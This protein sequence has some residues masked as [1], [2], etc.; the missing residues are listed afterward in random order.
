MED[1]ICTIEVSDKFDLSQTSHIFAL[2][3]AEKNFIS[4]TYKIGDEKVTVF[5]DTRGRFSMVFGDKV[6]PAVTDEDVEQQ[7]TDN[8]DH[9]QSAVMLPPW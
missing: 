7:I 1:R 6:P 2:A 4:K 9:E 3:E 5:K 8:I